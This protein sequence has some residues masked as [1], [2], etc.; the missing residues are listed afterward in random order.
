MRLFLSYAPC[1]QSRDEFMKMIEEAKQYGKGLAHR[2]E[3]LHCTLAYLGKVK[4]EDYDHLVQILRK[5]GKR[6]ASFDV[7]GK[8]IWLS[9]DT[10]V[11]HARSLLYLWENNSCVQSIYDDLC[12]Q[13]E[14]HGYWYAEHGDYMPHTTLFMSYVPFDEEK[15]FHASVLNDH[16]DCIVLYQVTKIDGHVAYY[17]LF[18][19]KLEG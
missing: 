10:S 1:N 15:I 13:L 14:I 11:Y 2:Y 12:S 6:H 4:D 17:P 19:Q 16:F 18:V 7:Q 9:T 8:G 3:A 5:V